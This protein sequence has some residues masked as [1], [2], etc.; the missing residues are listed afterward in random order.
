MKN[1]MDTFG[2]NT[3]YAAI[4]PEMNPLAPMHGAI[5]D[6]KSATCNRPPATPESKASDRYAGTP[7]ASSTLSP[8]ISR[9]YRFPSK[10]QKPPC[11]NID[12]MKVRPPLRSHCPG[13]SPNLSAYPSKFRNVSKWTMMQMA[14][15]AHVHQGRD[16]RG[17]AP[18]STG[19]PRNPAAYPHMEQGSGSSSAFMLAMACIARISLAFSGSSGSG[20]GGGGL[21]TRSSSSGSNHSSWQRQHTSSSSSRPPSGS[22]TSDIERPHSGQGEPVPGGLSFAIRQSVLTNSGRPHS[23]RTA[24][25]VIE[26]PCPSG[27]R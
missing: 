24:G 7:S 6:G 2:K 25:N 23:E 4:T 10:C 8:N 20:G 19:N 9:K 13:I 27:Q 22:R 1:E 15:R 21:G 12:E 17:G 16:V 5:E 26:H 11:R 18:C 14:A 3:A